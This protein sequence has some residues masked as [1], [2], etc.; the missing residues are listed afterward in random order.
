MNQTSPLQASSY[1]PLYECGVVVWWG[2]LYSSSTALYTIQPIHHPSGTTCA[3]AYTPSTVAGFWR[4]NSLLVSPLE[5]QSTRSPIDGDPPLSTGRPAIELFAADR[6][7]RAGVS[8]R[9][10]AAAFSIS[11]SSPPKG[12]RPKPRA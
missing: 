10:R 7:P 6:L 2:S 8:L 3:N 4:P 12:H 5:A 1:S 11:S 9:A